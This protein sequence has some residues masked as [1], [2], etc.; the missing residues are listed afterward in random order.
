VSLR[1]REIKSFLRPVSAL[2]SLWKEGRMTSMVAMGRKRLL[3]CFLGNLEIGYS[4]T[5]VGRL[6][7]DFKLPSFPRI[8]N[9]FVDVRRK[10]HSNRKQG[11]PLVENSKHG[12]AMSTAQEVM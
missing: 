5:S 2:L 12:A 10:D 8:G 6:P 11:R 4:S 9:I 1:L 7:S 3:G